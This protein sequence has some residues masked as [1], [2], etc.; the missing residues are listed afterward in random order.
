MST[1]LIESATETPEL[2]NQLVTL[3]NAPNTETELESLGVTSL[4][5]YVKM[6]NC[7]RFLRFR[8]AAHEDRALRA[9]WSVEIQPIGKLL[10]E[11]ENV[12]LIV[13]DPEKNWTFG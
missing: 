6:Q 13:F 1:S 11:K 5:Q 4:S 7:D 2:D 10:V 12:H 8:L 3:A 9:K